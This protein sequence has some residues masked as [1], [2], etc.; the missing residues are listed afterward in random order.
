MMLRMN[1]ERGAAV[2]A[3]A[4]LIVA[5]ITMSLSD[6]AVARTGRLTYKG[7]PLVLLRA[8]K[9]EIG[10]FEEFNVND[11]NPFIPWQDRNDQSQL[12]SGRRKSGPTKPVEKPVIRPVV[13]P[14]KL[15]LPRLTPAIPEA[16]RAIG[17]IGSADYA[18]LLVRSPD[19]AS[20]IP[21]PIGGTTNGWTLLEVESGNVAVWEDPSGTKHRFPIGEGT[22]HEPQQLVA[23]PAAT[24]PTPATSTPG[25]KNAKPV[26]PTVPTRDPAPKTP[27]LNKTKE[28]PPLPKPPPDQM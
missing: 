9:P 21:V 13:K 2:A 12:I 19:A 6:P 10:P 15:V 24:A 17:L 8:S 11:D 4:V 23:Q 25:D 3:G 7:A 22:L 26:K 14:P 20:D 5:L 1:V 18:V 16:P 27:R 28:S